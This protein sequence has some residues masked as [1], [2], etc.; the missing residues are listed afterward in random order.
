[1]AGLDWPTPHNATLCRRQARIAVEIPYR[2]S[3]VPPNLLIDIEPWNPTGPSNHGEAASVSAAMASG[4]AQAWRDAKAR[5][6]EGS[7][8]HGHFGR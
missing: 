7:S 4:F 1:M 6:A 2:H 8:D 5:M 3:E